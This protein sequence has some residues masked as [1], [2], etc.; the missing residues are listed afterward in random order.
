MTGHRLRTAVLIAL[1]G[2]GLAAS[3]ALAVLA[4]S[5]SVVVCGLLLLAAVLAAV[6]LRCG[7]P[8]LRRSALAYSL[9]CAAGGVSL[10]SYGTRALRWRN[11]G[12]LRGDWGTR[13]ETESLKSRL[14]AGMTPRQT[15]TAMQLDTGLVHDLASLFWRGMTRATALEAMGTSTTPLAPKNG[16]GQLS[17]YVWCRPICSSL[18]RCDGAVLIRFRNGQLDRVSLYDTYAE[19]RIVHYE[20]GGCIWT[21]PWGSGPHDYVRFSQAKTLE[22]ILASK[23]DGETVI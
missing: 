13:V 18:G 6:G 10:W 21:R 9:V 11:A 5:Y 15:L 8:I 1:I 16:D 4:L 19:I 7:K 3:A 2:L 23:S 22:A 20:A 12:A 17:Y 14:Q